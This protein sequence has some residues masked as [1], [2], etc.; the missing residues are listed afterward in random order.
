[1]Y[2]GK[3]N[4]PGTGKRKEI[5]RWS[6]FE[7]VRAIARAQARD[8]VDRELESPSME[9]TDGRVVSQQT[10]WTGRVRV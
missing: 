6:L 1:M 3:E 9:S 10:V 5:G 2:G 8:A 4:G 7:W